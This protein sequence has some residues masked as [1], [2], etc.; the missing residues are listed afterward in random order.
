MKFKCCFHFVCIIDYILILDYSTDHFM[1]GD[2][3]NSN[4]IVGFVYRYPQITKHN[5]TSSKAKV[6]Q[7]E[8]VL[9][10]ILW[11]FLLPEESFEY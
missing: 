1:A 2:H 7:L 3:F 4:Y 8:S 9:K 10:I 5:F 6:L 11:L